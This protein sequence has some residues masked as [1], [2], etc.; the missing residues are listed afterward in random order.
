MTREL[1]PAWQVLASH[2]RLLRLFAPEHG[3]WGVAQDMEAVSAGAVEG[4]EVL[5][6]YGDSAAS[7]SPRPED[8][9]D[10][11]AVVVDLPDIGCRYYTYAA[12]MAHL[13]AACVE[14][15]VEVIVCDR[16]NPLTGDAIEGG[17]VDGACRS[18]VSELDVPARHGLTLGELALLIRDRRHL[19][20]SLSVVRCTGWRRGQWWDETGL[21]WVAPSPNMPTLT[22]ATVYPGACLVEATNLSEGRGTTRPFQLLGAPWLDGDA[23]ARDLNA[24]NLPGALFRATRFRPEFGKHA[25]VVCGGVEWHV[26]DRR[27][28]RPV[29]VG[30]TFLKAA[31][32][33]A[34]DA[35]RWREEPYEFVSD[36]PAVDLL[37]GSPEVRAVV[38]GQGSEIELWR[39]WREF[40]ESFAVARRQHLVYSEQRCT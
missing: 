12:T 29:A 34:P 16:P 19:D 8:V 30:V 23:L 36:V 20:L 21:P 32:A 5:S 28:M 24:W 9:A 11:D 17:G 31:R 22:T 10:L 6:L 39:G 38:E 18:F 37:T 7:L 2:G 15:G 4:L 35:F 3:L 25:G 13:M 27:A 14:A 26:A 40:E 1:K 33:Q